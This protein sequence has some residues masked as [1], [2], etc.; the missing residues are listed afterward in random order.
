MRDPSDRVDPWRNVASSWPRKVLLEALDTAV[1]AHVIAQVLHDTRA[2]G[3][4]VRYLPGRVTVLLVLAMGLWPTV[5]LRDCLRNLIE[6][7]RQGWHRLEEKV[8]VRSAISAARDRLG[9]RP[10]R[11]LFRAVVRPLATPNTKG[12]FYKGFRLVAFDGS[13]LNVPDTQEND[14]V[15]GR[16]GSGRGRAA[17]PKVR[18]V[19]LMEAAT[20]A[21]LD[22]IALPYRVAEQTGVRRLFRS[23]QPGMLVLWDRGFHSYSLWKALLKARVEVLARVKVGLVFKP[24]RSLADGSF[25]AKVYPDYNDRRKDRHGILVRVIEYTIRDPARPGHGEKHRLITSLLDSGLYPALK[26]ICLYHER[27][28]IELGLDEIKVHQNENRL[29]LRSKKPRGVMQEI[30]G[31]MLVHF[32]LCHLRHEAALTIDLDPDR[33]SFV[34]TLRV[35]RRAIPSFQ[36]APAPLLPHLYRQMLAEITEEILP[37]RRTRYYPRVVKRKMSNFRVKQECHRLQPQPTK[38]FACTVEVL[39]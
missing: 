7:C 34:H 25:L 3:K 23:L 31:L 19:W 2:T 8:P 37:E 10:L 35:L 28:E 6:G 18:L 13:T 20:R 22:F 38:P 33:I 11:N 5:A 15:F 4:R 30:H 17:F 24:I 1:P 39:K 32:A 26:L 14:R 29:A 9:V 27:W 12:A 21:A 36:S 16:P